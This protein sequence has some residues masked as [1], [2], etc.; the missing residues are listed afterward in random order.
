MQFF[1][2]WF[3]GL[4]SIPG[5]CVTAVVCNNPP[6]FLFLC[7][8]PKYE[9]T[10][11]YPKMSSVEGHLSF[12][13]KTITNNFTWLL[14]DTRT[15]FSWVYSKNW[16]GRSVQ[17]RH[18]VMSDSLQTHG[19]QHTRLPCLSPIPGACSNSCP[20]SRWCHS[21]ISSSVIPFSSCLQSFP[22]SGSLP[23]S[24][25]FASGGQ[26]TGSSALALI[27]PMNIQ[28]WFTRVRYSQKIFHKVCYK[29]GYPYI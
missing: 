11:V 2:V 8:I 27:L 9:F 4:L 21:A 3:S 28:D 23:M 12:Q 6:F 5:R 18:S 24:W 22:T 1:L 7:N 25:F 15:H 29:N 17:F 19:L 20:L 26:S 14:V 10:K 16:L 13:A